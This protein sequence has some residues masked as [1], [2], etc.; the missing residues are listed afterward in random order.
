MAESNA[1]S[2]ATGRRGNMASAKSLV[3]EAVEL[4]ALV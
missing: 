4:V 2:V 1:E 3:L